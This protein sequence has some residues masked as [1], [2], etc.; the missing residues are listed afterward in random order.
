M[1]V[2]NEEIKSYIPCGTSP[3][4]LRNRRNEIGDLAR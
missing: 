2:F 3:A 4:G 1:R